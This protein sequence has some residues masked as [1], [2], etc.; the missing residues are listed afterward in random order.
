MPLSTY[1]RNNA[2]THGIGILL[3]I[4]GIP[5][6]MI[7]AMTLKS[8][9]IEIGAIVFSFGLLAVFVSSTSYHLVSQ[10]E[11]KKRLRKIDH[12]AIYFLIGG[13]Y[14][15]YILFY[16]NEGLG[17]WFLGIH[18]FLILVGVVF[19]LFFTGRF[20]LLST[21]FYLVLGWMVLPIIK[22]LLE[23]MPTEVMS[24]VI[25]GGVFY[26]VGVIFYI[27]E[28]YE[29]NHAIWHLFVLAGAGA[30]FVGLYLSYIAP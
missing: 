17:Y 11:W 14:T 6:L 21:L 18:W 29:V 19:K 12:I 7:A 20:E 3:S 5:F 8:L 9:P 25:A 30:H 4:I 23:V 13:T 24:Y 26:S 16:L 15:A 1:E 2:I 27:W 28:K 22:P 10:A